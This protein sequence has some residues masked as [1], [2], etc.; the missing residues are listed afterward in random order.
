MIDINIGDKVKINKTIDRFPYDMIGSIGT[1]VCMKNNE[2]FFDSRIYGVEFNFENENFHD[3]F[4]YG[5]D[6]HCYYFTIDCISK[7]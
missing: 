5:K 7:E 3:V 1:V 4:G 6:K 2:N